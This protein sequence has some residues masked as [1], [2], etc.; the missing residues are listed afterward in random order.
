M[1]FLFTLDSPHRSRFLT[2]RGRIPA[3]VSSGAQDPNKNVEMQNS[4][5]ERSATESLW[6]R[7]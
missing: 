4:E 6:P 1:F 2:C 7:T 5:I 3:A